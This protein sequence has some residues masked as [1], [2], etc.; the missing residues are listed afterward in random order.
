MKMNMKDNQTLASGV[1]LWDGLARFSHKKLWSE[2]VQ[3]AV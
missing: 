2:Y 3:L 1:S